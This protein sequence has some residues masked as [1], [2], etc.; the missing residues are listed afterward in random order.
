MRENTYFFQSSTYCRPR[1]RARARARMIIS[2]APW[3]HKHTC[4][5]NNNNNKSNSFDKDAPY[6]TINGSNMIVIIVSAMPTTVVMVI[7]VSFPTSLP[8]V[9]LISSSKKGKIC[10]LCLN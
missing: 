7:A 9:P 8:S 6:M 2:R 1:A 4:R 3:C 10:I 5:V